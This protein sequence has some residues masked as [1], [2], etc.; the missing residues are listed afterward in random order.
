[1]SRAKEN[2]KNNRMLSDSFLKV[3]E[4]Y[5]YFATARIGQQLFM[6]WDFWLKTIFDS[7]LAFFN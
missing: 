6:A 2:G 7:K 1:M 4:K 5:T 3:G